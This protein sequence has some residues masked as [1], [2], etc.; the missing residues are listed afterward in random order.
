MG[1][2][3]RDSLSSIREDEIRAVLAG[4]SGEAD[5]VGLCNQPLTWDG[6]ANPFALLPRQ[7]A[8]DMSARQSLL[9]HSRDPAIN[10][11]S[12][13]LNALQVAQ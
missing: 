9:P 3:R 11:N 2:W 12:E 5:A 10:Q 1:L 4:L 8:A 13:H 6:A 7:P